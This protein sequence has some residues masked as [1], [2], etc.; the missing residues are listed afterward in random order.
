MASGARV[1]TPSVVASPARGRARRP[2]PGARGA[3]ALALAVAAWPAEALIPSADGILASAAR[4]REA[5]GVR[6]LIVEGV[7]RRPGQDDLKVRELLLAG[8]GHRVELGEGKDQLVILTLGARQW[9]WRAGERPTQSTLA[10]PSLVLAF[11]GDSAAHAA[12]GREL[13]AAYDVDDDVVALTRLDRQIAFSIGARAWEPDKPQL[14]I[15]KSYRTPVRLV[16][17]DGGG[18]RVETRLLGWGAAQ[19]G[20]WWPQRIERWVD[21]Q[22]AEVTVYVELLVNEPLDAGLFRPPPG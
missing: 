17:V 5:L 20:E 6:T 10:R 14:W 1:D 8:A 3:L 22:R 12:V 21:G 4:R 2:A 16:E 18:H 15:D 7:L 13:L 11:L 9:R 19:T